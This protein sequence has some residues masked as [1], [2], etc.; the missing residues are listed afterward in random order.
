MKEAHYILMINSADA[1]IYV[2]F[3]NHH[4]LI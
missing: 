3:Y 1:G 4:V 2:V